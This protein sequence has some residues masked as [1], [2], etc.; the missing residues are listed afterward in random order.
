M[1]LTHTEISLYQKN[2][3]IE[4]INTNYITSYYKTSVC[5]RFRLASLTVPGE[6]RETE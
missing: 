2:S 5:T 1:N 3:N 6:D 4:A